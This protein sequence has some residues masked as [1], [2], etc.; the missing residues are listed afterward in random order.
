[1]YITNYIYTI[2]ENSNSLVNIHQIRRRQLPSVAPAN[3]QNSIRENTTFNQHV[4]SSGWMCRNHGYNC[5]SN[6]SLISPFE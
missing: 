4:L 2:S 1:M 6:Y 5:F 3:K